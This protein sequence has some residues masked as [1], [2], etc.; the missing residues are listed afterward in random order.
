MSS[1]Q[2]GWQFQVIVLTNHVSVLIHSVLLLAIF[3]DNLDQ[4]CQCIDTQCF[5]VGNL[6]QSC[7]CID[8]QCITVGNF[9]R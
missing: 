3:G 5:T 2:Y 6:D 1:V 4:S 8:T 7:Q 9:R